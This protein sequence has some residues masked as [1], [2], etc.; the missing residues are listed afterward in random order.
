MNLPVNTHHNIH[1][2]KHIHIMPS[3]NYQ[4]SEARFIN[5]CDWLDKQLQTENMMV[6]VTN[7]TVNVLWLPALWLQS[8]IT[9][10]VIFGVKVQRGETVQNQIMSI[11]AQSLWLQNGYRFLKVVVGIDKRMVLCII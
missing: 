6:C 10:S 3:G 1:S 2:L 5:I 9:H 7:M 11:T 4:T 8:C